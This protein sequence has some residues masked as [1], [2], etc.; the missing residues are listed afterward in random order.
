M[1]VLRIDDIDA[2]LFWNNNNISIYIIDLL[3]RLF[4]VVSYT[5]IDI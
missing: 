5:S 4:V 3:C 2:K 1:N